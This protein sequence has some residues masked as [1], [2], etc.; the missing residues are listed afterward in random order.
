MMCQAPF[1]HNR[2]AAR[3]N[4]CHAIAGHGN[5]GQSNA[6]MNSEV[7]NTL[8]GLFNECVTEN[9]PRPM[10]GFTMYLFKAMINRYSVVRNRCVP[11]VTF[12]GIVVVLARR[13]TNHFIAPREYH[14]G[15]FYVLITEA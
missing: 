9:L 12:A 14:P 15:T 8:F 13:Q 6:C 10:F 1:S 3:H 7:I 2:S 11:Y 4:P 5:D